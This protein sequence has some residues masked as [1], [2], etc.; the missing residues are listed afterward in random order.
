V[1]LAFATIALRRA[2][3]STPPVAPTPATLAVSRAARSLD[4]PALV[5]ET[6]APAPPAT[7][8]RPTAKS[9]RAAARLTHTATSAPAPRG[10]GYLTISSMPWG[11]VY[12]DGK[13]VAAQTP[14]YRLPVA[15]GKHQVAILNPTRNTRS[16]TKDVSV[17]GGAV[18]VL[19]FEW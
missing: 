10:I 9:P 14:V 11:A 2:N 19:G 13:R 8:P 12:V 7:S 6:Q 3:T 1:A 15:A 16:P 5:Q 18:R 17:E 4:P